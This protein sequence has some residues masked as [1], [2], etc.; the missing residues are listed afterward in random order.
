MLT[1]VVFMVTVAVGVQNRPPTAPQDSF[2]VPDYKLFGSPS[3]TE[4][5]SAVSSIVYAYSGTPG[6][7]PVVKPNRQTT[8]QS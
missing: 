8:Y 3:F 1:L 6:E 2:W 5:I 4:A 7:S